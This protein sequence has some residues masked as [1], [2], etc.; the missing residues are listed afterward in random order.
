MCLSVGPAGSDFKD[1][2]LDIMPFFSTSCFSGY[3][4]DS[5]VTKIVH[6]YSF[7][8]KRLN[9]AANSHTFAKYRVTYVKPCPKTE[10]NCIFHLVLFLVTFL[11]LALTYCQIPSPL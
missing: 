10:V 4:D 1:D 3:G 7:T 9:L 8:G 2:S 11:N 5:K 6:I